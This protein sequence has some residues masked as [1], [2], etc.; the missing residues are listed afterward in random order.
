MFKPTAWLIGLV[1]AG[2]LAGCGGGEPPAPDVGA[3]PTPAGLVAGATVVA[4]TARTATPT[5]V[6]PLSPVPSQAIDGVV[7]PSSAELVD[8]TP[9][10]DDTDARVDYRIDGVETDELQAW[11]TKHMPAL[12]WDEPEARDD[13]LV[14]LHTRDLSARHAGLGQKR[15]AMVVF[16]LED[17]VDFTLLVEAPKQ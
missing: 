13:A 8:S 5:P 2:T 16:D 4:R 7:V 11:F 12:G 3:T 1:S 9:A 14:F 15:T 6:D 10:T 17:G